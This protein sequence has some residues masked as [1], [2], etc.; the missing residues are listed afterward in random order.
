[1]MLCSQQMD[2][3][4][5]KGLTRQQ[6]IKYGLLRLGIGA[7]LTRIVKNCVP[8]RIAPTQDILALKPEMRP[9]T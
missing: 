2:P 8:R 6:F 3:Q 4:A 1:M 5:L 7:Q 9:P